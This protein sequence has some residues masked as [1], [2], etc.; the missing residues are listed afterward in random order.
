MGYSKYDDWDGLVK[1]LDL[2]RGD[3]IE[4]M[5]TMNEGEYDSICT[6][7]PYMIN[8]AGKKWDAPFNV[9]V[10]ATQCFRVLKSGGYMVC[11]GATRTIHKFAGPLE[12]AGFVI[13][14]MLTWVYWE[15]MPHSHDLGLALD[16]AVGVESKVVGRKQNN[17]IGGH[18]AKE[19]KNLTGYNKPRVWEKKEPASDMGI[20]FKGYG[21]GLKPCHEPILL[22]QKPISEKN[23]AQNIL[24]HGVGG[25]NL[26]GCRHG[27]GDPM[28]LGPQNDHSKA[29]YECNSIGYKDQFQDSDERVQ[30]RVDMSAF[31][32]KGGRW[33]A[34]VLH[35]HKPNRTEREAGLE[36]LLK[37][38][39]ESP[40]KIKDDERAELAGGLIK[41]PRANIHMTVK[42]VKLMR[43]LVRLITPPEGKVLDPFMGSGTTGMAAILE[44]CSPTGCEL[45]DRYIP[46]IEGRCQWARDEYKRENAQQKLPW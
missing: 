32:P 11:F 26:D 17:P 8:L 12:E 1:S 20:K 9:D 34:N 21:T 6:D 43:W 36:H 16:K 4:I 14:D 40:Y 44:G 28:W 7:P 37:K 3:C 35:C 38:V 45:T 18:I 27:Y 24:R 2:R 29:W 22:L 42:P 23:I 10:W 33:A 19:R 31:A 15:G 41:T 30:E 5:K 46:I 13:K 39:P 25:L